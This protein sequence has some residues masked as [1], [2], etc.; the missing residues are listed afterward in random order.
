[1]EGIDLFVKILVF[2]NILSKS[3]RR[4]EGGRNLDPKVQEAS[5]SHLNMQTILIIYL[6]RSANDFLDRRFVTDLVLFFIS[7]MTADVKYTSSKLLL[8]NI[9]NAK[10]PLHIYF[11]MML[12]I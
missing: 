8:I 4:R 5:L 1:M 11:P 10:D 6:F 12:S 2:V 9:N 7:N 3:R